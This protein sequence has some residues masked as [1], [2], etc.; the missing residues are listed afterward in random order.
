VPET[1]DDFAPGEARADVGIRT[2]GRVVTLLGFQRALVGAAVL[3]SPQRADRAG[4]AGI[5]IGAGAGDDACRKRGG[6]ELVLGVQD[7]RGVHGAHPGGGRRLAVHQVQEVPADRIIRGLDLDALPAV[8]EV[9]PVGEHRAEG[10]DQ[11]VGDVT[12]A[13][14]GMLLLF[15]RRHPS[16]EVPVRST[17]I[18]CATAGSASSTV[19]RAPA[20][21][22]VT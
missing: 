15:R 9:I 5:D 8:A 11:A 13:G 2:R 20:G 21:R 7:Q 22:A 14:S 10:C 16:A 19:R 12:C 3:R 6:V 1:D 17:S 4:D 18:G